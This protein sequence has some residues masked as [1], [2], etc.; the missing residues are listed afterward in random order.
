MASSGSQWRC[1]GTPRLEVYHNEHSWLEKRD[2]S[3]DNLSKARERNI[4]GPVAMEFNAAEFEKLSA[5]GI[6]QYFEQAALAAYRDQP[7]KY[8]IHTDYFEGRVRVFLPTG[9]NKD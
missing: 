5:K 8:A 3:T 7:D 6:I 1:E 2:K 9:L 4:G